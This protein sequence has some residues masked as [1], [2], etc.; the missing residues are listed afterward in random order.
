MFLDPLAA[1]TVI[2]SGLDITFVPLDVQ[3]RVSSFPMVIQ[4]LQLRIK[5]PEAV[6]AHRL[7]S[8]L[9][10]LQQLH[11]RY[12]HMDMFLGE[13]LGAIIL[14]N[15]PLIRP[16]LQETPINVSATGDVSVDGQVYIDTKHGRLV[17]ILKSLDSEAYYG[18]FTD[19]LGDRVQSA[20]IG[21]FE[22]QKKIWSK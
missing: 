14:A 8:R 1:K 20:V 19:M 7:L 3:Q 9:H 17:N 6:F 12:H 21:S 15:H 5:T 2:E 10:H 22:E 16:V 18:H 4:K 13:I 11:H